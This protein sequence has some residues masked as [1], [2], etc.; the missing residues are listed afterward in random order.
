MALT[1]SVVCTT[2]YRQDV[3]C[4]GYVMPSSEVLQLD[5]YAMSTSP[6]SQGGMPWCTMEQTFQAW[7]ERSRALTA[8]DWAEPALI[9]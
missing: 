3:W 1:G 2:A 9:G 6:Q 7:H 5:T 4:H 8:L